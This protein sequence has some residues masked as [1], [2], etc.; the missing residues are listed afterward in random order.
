MQEEEVVMPTFNEAWDAIV[1]SIENVLYG[2]A[3]E[4]A[5]MGYESAKHVVLGNAI[6]DI[7]NWIGVLVELN[8]SDYGIPSKIARDEVLEM[9][10][11]VS[12]KF[13]HEFLQENIDKV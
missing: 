12:R 7:I 5:P 9:I 13:V 1:K 8:Q 6:E 3:D 2:I 11:D 10:Y 4:L